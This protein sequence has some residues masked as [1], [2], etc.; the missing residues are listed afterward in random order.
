MNV[1]ASRHGNL[2]PDRICRVWGQVE[3]DN[4]HLWHCPSTAGA[5][6]KVPLFVPQS[7][8][9]KFLKFLEDAASPSIW[10]PHCSNT[11]EWEKSRRIHAM[12]KCTEFSVDGIIFCDGGCVF[13][14][15]YCQCG[16]LLVDHNG[17]T[18]RGAHNEPQVADKELLKSLSGW[19]HL[20]L[21]ER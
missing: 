15:D 10:P 7:I 2:Y 20:T 4:N 17:L 8:T 11:V 5:L 21:M 3:E 16:S 6:F 18:C 19:R 14:D 9:H 1:T 13:H 12:A